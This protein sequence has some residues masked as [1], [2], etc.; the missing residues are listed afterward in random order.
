[1]RL[2]EG[3]FLFSQKSRP[4]SAR[5]QSSLEYLL[6][7]AAFFG[8]LGVMLPVIFQ[9]TNS[10]EAWR[11]V[12]QLMGFSE[13]KESPYSKPK[14]KLRIILLVEID[15]LKKHLL[16]N[17]KKIVKPQHRASGTIVQS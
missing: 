1:M 2:S 17:G 16:E 7:L 11:N 8:V 10:G 3:F 13:D 6:I 15:N 9:T 4:F 12:Q 14:S 5:A